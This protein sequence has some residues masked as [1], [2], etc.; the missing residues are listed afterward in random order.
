VAKTKVFC[1]GFQKTGTTSMDRA[2][3]HFGYQVAG[4]FGLYTPIDELRRT[5]V[6]TGL[7]IAAKHDAVQDTPWPL[8]YREL[9]AAFPGSRFI[10]TVRDTDSWYKSIASHFVDTPGPLQE[11]TYGEDAPA[12]LGHEARYRQVYEGHNA[13]V[14]DYFK[15]RPKDFLVMDLQAGDGWEKLCPFIGEPTP[16][17][18]FLHANPAKVRDTLIYRAASKLRKLGIRIPHDF[19]R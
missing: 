2:L 12:P 8:L 13:A 4:L 15:D 11:L 5:Y 9:D 7:D 17:M 1:I 14:L 18:P 16:D 3:Q 19:A 6:E 10:L